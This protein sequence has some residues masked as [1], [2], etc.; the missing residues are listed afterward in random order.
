[1]IHDLS[2]LTSDTGDRADL[3][4]PQAVIAEQTGKEA[5]AEA[6]L[7]RARRGGGGASAVFL[8]DRRRGARGS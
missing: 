7:D 8:L 4:F 6:I 5:T 2:R 3:A 1:M